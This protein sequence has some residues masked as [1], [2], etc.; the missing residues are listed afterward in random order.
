VPVECRVRTTEAAQRAS[1]GPAAAA[2][3]ADSHLPISR[4]RSRSGVGSY[5]DRD[6]NSRKQGA[7]VPGP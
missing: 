6:A 4:R 2:A 7:T 3:D 1:S 5:L